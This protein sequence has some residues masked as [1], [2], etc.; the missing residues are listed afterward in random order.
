VALPP[1]RRSG[2][3]LLELL[4]VLTLMAVAVAAVALALRDPSAT[5]LEREAERLA[6]LLE[7]G[8]A[9]S[10]ASGL[11]VRWQPLRSP[12]EDGEHFRFHGLPPGL[13]LPQRWLHDGVHAEIVGATALNLGP[14]PVIGAQQVT[15]VLE[16]RRVTLATD[17]LQPFTIVGEA[18]RVP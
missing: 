4:V 12:G 13:A 8:R 5:R 2:F 17:G 3:T 6:A 15:L 10:R 1:R 14:E 9:E 7:A 11:P 16:D 18:A